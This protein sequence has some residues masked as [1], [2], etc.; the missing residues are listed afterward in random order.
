MDRIDLALRV[1][2]VDPD[3]LLDRASAEPSHV[4]R[5]RVAEAVRAAEERGGRSSRL[6]GAAL[7]AACGLSRRTRAAVSSCSKAFNLSGRGV[8]R[9][10]RVAR[11]IADLSG[12]ACVLDE[13]VSE[14]STYRAALL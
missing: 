13:H 6:S 14:A 1:D 10:L 11:T 8:T 12:S 5:A 3:S 2:R 7:L 4:V 9:L